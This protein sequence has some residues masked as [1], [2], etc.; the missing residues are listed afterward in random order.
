MSDQTPTADDV[1]N[2]EET[3]A[4]FKAAALTASIE[5]RQAVQAVFEGGFVGLADRLEALP[6]DV[7]SDPTVLHHVDA[8]LRGISGLATPA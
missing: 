7:R 8:I 6:V 5:R 4:R 1:R 2:A 3:I